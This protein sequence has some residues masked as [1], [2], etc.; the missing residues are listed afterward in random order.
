MDR[1]TNLRGDK[2]KRSQLKTYSP[3]RRTKFERKGY[4]WG[5]GSALKR[6]SRLR[7]KGKKVLAWDRERRKLKID[8]ARNE[9]TTCELRGV[10]EH[11]CTVDD[12]LGYAHP[13][14]R[15]KLSAEDLKVAILVCNSVHDLLERMKPEEMKRIVMGVWESRARKNLLAA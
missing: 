15:R 11:D 14:K 6:G 7:A 10:I 13:A 4:S 5:A 12:Y 1:Q 2:L 3:L 9:R 8:S